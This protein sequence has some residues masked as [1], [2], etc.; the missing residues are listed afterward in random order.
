MT[1]SQMTFHDVEVA[2]IV[3]GA[4][5]GSVSGNA[6]ATTDIAAATSSQKILIDGVEYDAT[7]LTA[8]AKGA[9]ASLQ[10][11]EA[12]LMALHGLDAPGIER[13]ILQKWPSSISK[14]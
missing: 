14:A 10:F 12:K 2:E 9:I 7:N 1:N 3:S 11:A 4:I 5:G 8:A 6:V 13:S